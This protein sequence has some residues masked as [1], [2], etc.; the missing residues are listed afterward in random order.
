[1]NKWALAARAAKNTAVCAAAAILV[2][3]SPAAPRQSGNA[4]AGSEQAARFDK[5]QAAQNRNFTVGAIQEI[6]E[7]GPAGAPDLG[8]NPSEKDIDFWGSRGNVATFDNAEKLDMA[9]YGE[10]F[11]RLKRECF[12]G[13]TDSCDRLS[14]A[15]YRGYGVPVD[16]KMGFEFAAKGCEDVG[17]E[18][19]RRLAMGYAYGYGTTA[20]P[21]LAEYRMEDSCHT[22]Q[23]F[24]CEQL[25]EMWMPKE[26]AKKNLLGD[27]RDR[28]QTRLDPDYVEHF[29]FM[30]DWAHNFFPNAYGNECVN[31]ELYACDAVAKYDLKFGKEPQKARELLKKACDG[32]YAPSCG[33]LAAL[34]AKDDP[35]RLYDSLGRSCEQGDLEGCELRCAVAP[36]AQRA[37]CLSSLCKDKKYALACAQ[38][39]EL[40][41]KSGDEKEA[42]DLA[43][44]SCG[45]NNAS[46]C[47]M[48]SKLAKDGGQDKQSEE[49]AQKAAQA[50]KPAVFD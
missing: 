24:V 32:G 2:S 7:S 39:A 44:R 15:F 20:N 4:A 36:D 48:A 16:R 25:Q 9:P 31:G 47:L 50:D 42:L 18:S 26:Q 1:M 21:K 12:D 41:Q 33:R 6:T 30:A 10:P 29:G 23:A 5:D 40:A 17:T 45:L 13:L 43:S 3:C 19:C 37:S 14:E 11:V 46:G 22:G 28:L 8:D 49:F 34:E 38:G 27:L 35:K